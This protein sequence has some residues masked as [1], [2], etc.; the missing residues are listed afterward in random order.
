MENKK[1]QQ[2]S[3]LAQTYALKK[4]RNYGINTAPPHKAIIYSVPPCFFSHAA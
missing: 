1:I 3:R 4:T 2:V